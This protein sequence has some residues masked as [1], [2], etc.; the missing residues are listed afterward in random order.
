LIRVALAGIFFVSSVIPLSAPVL[1]ETAVV[2]CACAIGLS[3]AADPIATV[4]KTPILDNRRRPPA[5]AVRD[6]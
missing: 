6:T 2:V 4:A 3:S 5:L 1:F